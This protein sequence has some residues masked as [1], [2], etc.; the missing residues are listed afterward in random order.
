MNGREGTVIV[1]GPT[2]AG[3]SALALALAE[4]LARDG[5]PAVIVNAD[6]MQVYRELAVLTAR[7]TAADRARAP[8]RLYG[9]LPAAQACS[10]GRWRRDAL[11]EI[12]DARAAGR[13]PL[14]VGGS[15]LYIEALTEGLASTPPVPA[16]VRRRADALHA[17]MGAA[18]F[19]AALAARDPAA[20]RLPV[21]DTQRVKRAWSVLEATGRPLAAWTAE[22]RDPLP[23][24][25]LRILLW[26]ER[27]ALYRRCA[28][29]F[30]AMMAQG[31]LEEA[32]ALAALGLDPR[33]P[34]MKALGVRP[35]LDGLAGVIDRAEAADRATRA[36]RR[37]AKRQRTWFR[38]RYRADLTIAPG[39][40]FPAV[41][42]ELCRRAVHR[43]RRGFR[44]AGIAEP[45][46][47]PRLRA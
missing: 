32:R 18:A 12:A 41:E 43:F 46:D 27:D 21:G 8:H 31:A 45:V 11:A 3:K 26:P 29:R 13:L 23:G 38:H 25:V 24:G 28:S 19:H 10:V 40:G 34:A 39:P 47:R 16:A 14:V 5:A 9:Y 44:D 22:A 42:A 15:G 35:L 37:Y 4:G 33:L 7:P 17:A 30:A 6:S 20:A 36:T 2:A 1:A